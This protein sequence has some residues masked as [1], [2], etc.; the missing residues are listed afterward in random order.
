V[1]IDGELLAKFDVAKIRLADM[2]RAG[3]VLRLVAPQQGLRISN[4][5]LR[6][7][8][9]QALPAPLARPQ[10]PDI[11]AASGGKSWTRGLLQSL[12][13]HNLTLAK[14]PPVARSQS[15][16]VALAP[17]AAQPPGDKDSG[18]APQFWV[19]LKDGS[20]FPVSNL[21]VQ[22]SQAVLG[23]QFAGQLHVPQRSLRRIGFAPPKTPRL[24][25]VD[26]SGLDVLTFR[27]GRQLRGTFAPPMEA[28]KIRWKLSASKA[29]LEFSADEASALRFAARP[30]L[31]PADGPQVLRLRNGDWLPGEIVAV[32]AQ[33]LTWKTAFHEGI[34]INRG[35]LGS[36]F[37]SPASSGML[38]DTASGRQPW[39]VRSSGAGQVY[40]NG[41]L[42]VE[43]EEV[44]TPDWKY[45]DGAYQ[46]Q[47]PRGARVSNQ[48]IALPLRPMKS[49]TSIEF[50]LD[51]SEG[52]FMMQIPASDGSIFA[53]MYG[54]SRYI[55]VTRNRTM[56]MRQNGDLQ[57]RGIFIRPEQFSFNLDERPSGPMRMQ[58]VFDPAGKQLHLA[59][60]GKKLG[61]CKFKDDAPW[62]DLKSIQFSG[63]YGTSGSLRIADVWV[64]P[65]A[66]RLGDTKPGAPGSV[67][68]FLANGDET[69]GTLLGLSPTEVEIDCDAG[70]LPLPLSRIQ[71]I[72]FN[73]PPDPAA[74]TATT[75]A[76]YRIRFYDRGIL[77]AGAV[78]IGET[79]LTASTAHG[80][81]S[82]PLPM[83]KELVFAKTE[84]KK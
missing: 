12:D 23:T 80:D 58:L 43:E 16:V 30:N 1:Q 32:D 17:P 68:L 25:G 82:I 18:A 54:S 39:K 56:Q 45:V 33:F 10:E 66:G 60:N 76:P 36:L 24:A 69:P 48:M 9:G 75:A 55:Q 49:P 11:L 2:N 5:V 50:A 84:A 38:A 7:W 72:D 57:N 79:T 28:A 20:S 63:S 41:R 51:G 34:K 22:N 53:S 21:Q 73:Q 67:S 46:L 52:Y 8:L 81:L 29:P 78:R 31:S 65:W 77:S 35:L 6:P 71:V 4:M 59:A 70:P 19:E 40:V 13:S 27:D 74:A 42:I 44:T 26:G 47:R 62:P 15:A 3:R 37:P 14:S 83:V 61:T 64:S